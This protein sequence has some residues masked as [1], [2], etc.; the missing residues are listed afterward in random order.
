MRKVQVNADGKQFLFEVDHA[1]ERLQ[2]KRGGEA[3]QAD[4]VKLKNNRYSLILDG[5]SH[6]IG[7]IYALDG[8]TI[9]TG[10]RSAKLLVEDYEIARMKQAAGIDE[11]GAARHVAAPMPGLIVQVHCRP[12]DIVEKGTALVVME[13][14]KMENDIRSPLAGRIKT[15]T[16]APGKSVDKGQ[17][18]VEFE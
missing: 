4:L 9:S 14:M 7:A 11:W 3:R 16:A 6:E 13:A 12:G 10:S 5:A 18:L 1:G 17:I 2:I 15:V 8:Y